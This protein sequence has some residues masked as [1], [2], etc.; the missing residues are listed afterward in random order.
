MSTKADEADFIVVYPDGLN[1]GWSDGT[2]PTGLRD[3]EFVRDLIG[4]LES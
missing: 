1:K 2:G 4:E 3:L